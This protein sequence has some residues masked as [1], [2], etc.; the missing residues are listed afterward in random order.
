MDIT[1]LEAVYAEFPEAG[2]GA[3]VTSSW[4]GWGTSTVLAHVIATRRSR[5]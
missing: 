2:K 3:V 4:T 5:R 1:E